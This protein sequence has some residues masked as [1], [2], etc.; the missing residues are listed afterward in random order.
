MQSFSLNKVQVDNQT[1]LV[2]FNQINKANLSFSKKQPTKSVL[3]EVNNGSNANSNIVNLLSDSENDDDT[4]SFQNILSKNLFDEN[5]DINITSR[6]EPRATRSQTR[7]EGGSFKHLNVSKLFDG[8]KDQEISGQEESEEI[9]MAETHSIDGDD[10]ID[11]DQ[12]DIE[13]LPSIQD[14]VIVPNSSK[15]TRSSLLRPRVNNITTSIINNGNNKEISNQMLEEISANFVLSSKNVGPEY[16]NVLVGQSRIDNSNI[17]GCL[18]PVDASKV[19]DALLLC[20]DNQSFSNSGNTLATFNGKLI[21]QKRVIELKPANIKCID[22]RKEHQYISF[23]NQPIV[24][25]N[26]I[27]KPFN[28]KLAP[29]LKDKTDD[30]KL[31]TNDPKK[32]L[33][34]HSNPQNV[35]Q[36]LDAPCSF[37]DE[38]I[39]IDDDVNINV[40]EPKSLESNK[41]ESQNLLLATV[42]SNNSINS[43]SKAIKS[44]QSGN[45]KAEND[46]TQ[47]KVFGKQ[48]NLSN[49]SFKKSDSE[50]SDHKVDKL[51]SNIKDTNS[52]FIKE[53]E[54][55]FDQSISETSLSEL[56]NSV[57]EVEMH[58]F[59]NEELNSLIECGSLDNNVPE[60]RQNAINMDQEDSSVSESDSN[61]GAFD[62]FAQITRVS[63]KS[64]S[65]EAISINRELK[66]VKQDGKGLRSDEG[67][68]RTDGL[69]DDQTSALSVTGIPVLQGV[70]SD[71]M[72]KIDS[73]RVAALK[74]AGVQNVSIDDI[75]E[76]SSDEEDSANS[77]Q[78]LEEEEKAK[79][80]GNDLSKTSELG[81][82]I[83]HGVNN[84]YN[85]INM[86]EKSISKDVTIIRPI[87]N[88]KSNTLNILNNSVANK[89]EIEN[90]YSIRKLDL[91]E[92][93]KNNIETRVV[94]IIDDNITRANKKQIETEL[95]EAEVKTTKELELKVDEQKLQCEENTKNIKETEERKKIE[96]EERKK[97][98]AEEGKIKE[99]L[100]KKKIENEVKKKKEEDERKKK[101]NED[102]QKN[103]A[104]E[105]RIK[106]IEQKKKIEVEEKRIKD[107]EQK[108]KIE[109]EEK[110]KKD[111]EEYNMKEQE[112]KKIKDDEERKI[113][114]NERKKIKD[115]EDDE[116]N[117]IK[118][119]NDVQE[120]EKKTF[121]AE[122]MK[123]VESAEITNKNNQN[124]INQE[125]ES[126]KNKPNSV[127]KKARIVEMSKEKDSESKQIEKI[128]IPKLD[129]SKMKPTEL[130]KLAKEADAIRAREVI[131]MEEITKTGVHEAN[132]IK[133]KKNTV[134]NA[135]EVELQKVEEAEIQEAKETELRNNKELE[136]KKS[137]EEEI[138]R[139]E[140]REL[141]RRAK[142][143]ELKKLQYNCTIL[144]P[145]GKIVQR[146]AKANRN[147][148]ESKKVVETNM[149]DNEDMK[150]KEV[151]MNKKIED[152]VSKLRGDKKNLEEQPKKSKKSERLVETRKNNV[153]ETG[154]METTKLKE[155][156]LKKN[157]VIE[158][159][160]TKETENKT[161][162]VQVITRTRGSKA[163][164]KHK[165]FLESVLQN[166]STKSGETLKFLELSTITMNSP[167]SSNNDGRKSIK[168]TDSDNH[169][170]GSKS[171]QKVDLGKNSSERDSN[172]NNK[173]E[174]V[175]QDITSKSRTRSSSTFKSSKAKETKSKSL[176]LS[177]EQNIVGS[178]PKGNTGSKTNI[179]TSSS[180]ASV[181]HELDSEIS[182]NK[183]T[184]NCQK[185]FSI[186]LFDL[187]EDQLFKNLPKSLDL[188]S[189]KELEN[190]E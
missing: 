70:I 175:Q 144:R 14:E 80:K 103:E 79:S 47:W 5:N 9:Q 18:I 106:D 49:I 107:D 22:A 71:V 168:N 190:K 181:N 179:E 84:K 23:A 27:K 163:E 73:D 53:L 134:E 26:K 99:A 56:Y 13:P 118:N 52:H 15:I 57:E 102:R 92:P 130:I 159:K 183:L 170:M 97:K 142:V 109:A 182:K 40:D 74:T 65:K 89:K 12:I 119:H 131:M 125:F 177:N 110:K 157:V 94:R 161:A 20:K 46:K 111:E 21:K 29:E 2:S 25:V 61:I 95:R 185:I 45:K 129:I 151:E 76:I 116:R 7:A 189:V 64:S 8:K 67:F 173:K 31:L 143:E 91:L 178:I 126:E 139:N 105:K 36:L 108:K 100:E 152:P 122:I 34:L 180:S 16:T 165:Q 1:N 128:H 120:A 43:N 10:L 186:T 117:K 38:V 86:I 6:L 78:Q 135:K 88:F 113:K 188:T 50:D 136:H 123:R 85:K 145:E 42:T 83:V 121:E 133:F 158:A 160:Q 77:T 69:D 48:Q 167:V 4:S 171:D 44:Y 187:D 172:E 93:N 146:E 28:I 114:D 166:P 19:K 176:N 66:V 150:V 140:E 30:I 87:I 17:T 39:V 41:V 174:D 81:T 154:S 3:P 63:Q 62:T 153:K 90:A 147:E 51:N 112:D 169:N 141:K 138:Q 164:E 115:K 54:F 98:E 37:S 127:M 33:K 162:E 155:Q 124:K 72:S 148:A 35:V 58:S 101:D 82:K 149:K 59:D 137:K 156:A 55:D 184:S 24:V 11:I 132:V 68:V 60:K 32:N 75:V 96:A 104:E